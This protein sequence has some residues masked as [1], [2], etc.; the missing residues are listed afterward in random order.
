MTEF[1]GLLAGSSSKARTG[2]K[3]EGELQAFL[4]SPRVNVTNVD[5]E[6]AQRYA[7]IV[8]APREGR[9][10]NPNQRRLDRGK[11]HAARATHHHDDARYSKIPQVLVNYFEP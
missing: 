3:Y 5:G 1:G 11:R 9:N 6:T 10:A 8:S 4:E 7:V 2:L